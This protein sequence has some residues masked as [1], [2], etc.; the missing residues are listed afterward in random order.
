MKDFEFGG[1]STRPM[2]GPLVAGAKNLLPGS[3]GL[4]RCA[5]DVRPIDQDPM[6]VIASLT[7]VVATFGFFEPSAHRTAKCSNGITIGPRRRQFR[8][9]HHFP[10]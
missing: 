1:P 5:D 7:G 2:P 6:A 10:M 4:Q 9:R 3:T 8:A